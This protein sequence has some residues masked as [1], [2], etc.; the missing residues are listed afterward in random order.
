M[1]HKLLDLGAAS[2]GVPPAEVA[3]PPAEAALTPTEAGI[4]KVRANRAKKS[5]QPRSSSMRSLVCSWSA[6]PFSRAGSGSSG[7][8]W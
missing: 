8:P 3:V 1:R 7:D 4:Q 2:A 6:S 5:R